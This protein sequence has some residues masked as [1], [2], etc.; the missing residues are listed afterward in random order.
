MRYSAGA[1]PIAGRGRFESQQQAE[2]IS[3]DGQPAM[4]LMA[5]II[6]GRYLRNTNDMME[7]FRKASSDLAGS[8]TLG[9]YVSDDLDNKWHSL[10]A[11]VKRSGVSLR[12]REATS[13][14][15]RPRRRRPG[16]MI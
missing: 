4:E 3:A 15:R 12:H 7:G 14:T 5:S 13:P 11:S 8:Y 9:F 10:K 2:R 6:G 1:M 16:R